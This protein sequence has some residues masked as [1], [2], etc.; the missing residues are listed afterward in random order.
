MDWGQTAI[1]LVTVLIGSGLIQ[2]FF[3]RKDKQKE[4]SKIDHDEKMKKEMKDH[5]TKVND[6]WRVD[7]CDKN[8]KAIADLAKE[9]KDGLAEREAKGLQRYEEHHLTIEK[10]N[11]QHQ[12]D[13]IALKEAIQKL[14][15]NDSKITQ[16][17]EKIAE[18]QDIMADS[19]I[20]Q[21]HDRIIFLTD[22]I[23][24]RGAITIKEKSTLASMYEPYRKLGG[25]G[26]C[27]TAVTYVNTL[28]VV[29][30]DEAKEMD[31]KIKNKQREII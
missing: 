6:Q 27:A 25:N 23:S 21:A 16:S 10:M 17:I 26:H 12:K 29:S 24:E 18:K 19:L 28:K 31:I 13:F 14:T 3:T 22:K 15:D 1:T 8:A 9:V 5:L 30:D 2:F 7:Y 4:D 20:G 11:V